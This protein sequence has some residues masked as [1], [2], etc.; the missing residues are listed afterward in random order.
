MIMRRKMHS[1]V[2]ELPGEKSWPA[3]T[4]FDAGGT[5]AMITAK[6]K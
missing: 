2:P 5:A 6:G 3:E 4:R 1:K